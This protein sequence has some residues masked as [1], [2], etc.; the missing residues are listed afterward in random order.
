MTLKFN[1]LNITALERKT[2]KLHLI[3]SF[4]E[5]IMAGMI[6]LNEIV[7][8]RSLNGPNA[9]IAILFQT[10]VI[11]FIF[12]ILLNEIMRRIHNKKRLLVVTGIITRIPLFVFLFFPK[13]ALPEGDAGF[14]HVVFL[15]IF[16]VYYMA[17]PIVVPTINLLLKTNYSHQ[18]FGKL[19]SYSTSVKKIVVIAS[20]FLFGILLDWD[21]YSYTY[22]FPALGII[23]IISIVLLARIEYVQPKGNAVRQNYF[24]LIKKSLFRFIAILK[25]NKPYR[26]FEIGFMM[27]GF[28][29][30]LSKAIIDIFMV[31]V[32][33]LNFSSIAFYK[34]I[35]NTLAIIILPYYGKLIGKIDP[36][37]YS[38]FTYLSMIF[39]VLFL[40]LG[41][42]IDAN[43]EFLGL[44]IYYI[45]LPSFISFGIFTAMMALQFY[46]GSAYFCK[47]HE[48]AD[49]QS[50]H[51]SLVGI[52]AL[53]SPLLGIW[54]FEL[55]GFQ[56]VF[57]IAIASLGIG[58]MV[59]IASM[60]KHKIL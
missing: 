37:R 30:M 19:Y 57:L 9:L 10:S 44:K 48:A 42:F 2:F 53:V 1:R 51:L 14:Y 27:Y 31:K 60:R 49:Y 6:L 34:N 7:F 52:R 17:N 41:E 12:S 35:Y 50:I 24:R 46:I 23:N 56:P 40:A 5:G 20:T 43:F 39:Y 8:L 21:N 58:I 4:L 11:I 28:A 45:L 59:L 3:Y 54:F 36:R 16:F 47:P 38:I 15:A 25:N 32:L 55:L 29:F 33:D 22:I 26:D 13:S 18:N